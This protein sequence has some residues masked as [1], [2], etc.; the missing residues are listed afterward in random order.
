MTEPIM[1]RAKGDGV[2]IQLAH[3]KGKRE[4][5]FCIHG[6]TANSRCWDR[7][8]SGLTPRF[9]VLAMDLRGRGLSDKPPTGYSI[10]QHVQ[11]IYCLLEDQGLERVTLMG[12]SLGAYISLAFAAH[13]PERVKN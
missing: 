3:W 5:I 1:K 2:G 10:E 13:H 4:N 8:I 7:I 12:H 11:D 9:Q 6:L